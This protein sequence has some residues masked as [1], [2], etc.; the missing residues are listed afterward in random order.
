MWPP[1]LFTY[2]KNKKA[3][4]G[5]GIYFSHLRKLE[6]PVVQKLIRPNSVL[7]WS[8]GA[9]LP[10]TAKSLIRQFVIMFPCRESLKEDNS[11][12]WRSGC[13]ERVTGL[14]SDAVY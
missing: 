6:V 12:S 5:K 13:A 10:F 3:L 1:S 2:R 7:Y 8:Q 11:L 14:N 4:A 9:S